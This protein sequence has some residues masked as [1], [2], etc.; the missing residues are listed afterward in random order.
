MGL[1]TFFYGPLVD[2]S[3]I[4]GTIARTYVDTKEWKARKK[5][6]LW[7][8]LSFLV[9]PA[10]ILFPYLVNLFIELPKSVLSWGLQLWVIRFLFFVLHHTNK[11]HWGFVAMMTAPWREKIMEPNTFVY[12]ACHKPEHSDKSKLANASSRADSGINFFVKQR[13]SP[14]NV[15]IIRL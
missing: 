15:N 11:Q 13:A 5:L 7:S 10:I 14:N 8:L 3:H 12:A 2:G 9:G 4:W 6:F 1:I